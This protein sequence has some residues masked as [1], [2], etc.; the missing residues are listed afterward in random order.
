[1]ASETKRITGYKYRGQQV[2]YAPPKLME[3]VQI[4]ALLIASL[5]GWGLWLN[6]PPAPIPTDQPTPHQL[7]TF[8]TLDQA[9]Q[10]EYLLTISRDA[11]KP[12]KDFLKCGNE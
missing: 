3:T 11:I 9:G 6:R 4:V 12:Y 10:Q 1:M 2:E 7:E 8:A 5:I